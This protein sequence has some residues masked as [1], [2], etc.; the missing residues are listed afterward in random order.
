LEANK[1][2]AK[3]VLNALKYGVI[4][5]A[6]LEP[7]STGREKELAELEGC[8][9]NVS[10]GNSAVKFISG[11][12]GSGKS[13]LMSLFGQ[14]A[15]R[16]GFLVSRVVIS[17]SFGLYSLEGLY[18]NIMHNLSLHGAETRGTE[19]EE[20]FDLWVGGLKSYPDR[21]KAS[22]EIRKVIHTLNNYNSSFARAFLTY[23]K[24]RIGNDTELSNAAASWIK[25]EKNIPAHL[26]L[27]FD[28]KGDMDRQNSMDFLKAFTSLV[29]LLGYKG[30]LIAVDEIELLMGLR[31]DLRKSAY[32][33]LRY[34]VDSCG[35]S[36]FTNCMFI[37]A[38][39]EEF[40]TDEEKGIKT[41]AALYQRLG[42]GTG[43]NSSF[44]D[45]RKPVMSLKK[46]GLE[47]IQALTDKVLRYHTEAYGWT[48]K[49]SSEAIR[50]WVLVEFKKTG[51][52]IASVNIRR[53]ITKLMEILDVMEQN[54]ENRLYC[55]ELRLIRKNGADMF[56]NP[57]LNGYGQE[58]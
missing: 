15:I 35:A 23:V 47:D 54:P 27:R 16:K 5:D 52:P 56:V 17:K 30:I 33:N 22:E 48:P 37:F 34:L 44:P 36:D 9:K 6:G 39:T 51:N 42:N 21:E 1:V 8:L 19:F 11:E 55:T 29:S 13:F 50:N 18:Y 12:Y 20:I 41:Y 38:G 24:A 40:F 57:A 31:S 49:I 46:L 10:E 3:R 2:N 25:G 53:Y 28:V 14:T 32:E 26:K 7:L 4:P 45:A 43:G 58:A